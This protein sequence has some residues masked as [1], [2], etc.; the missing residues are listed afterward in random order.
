MSDSTQKKISRIR[1]PRVQIT[2]DVEIGD[3]VEKK[4]L[5]FVVGV[6]ADLSGKRSEER[7]LPK[8]K[9]RKFVSIDRDNFNEVMSGIAPRLSYRVPNSLQNDGS[10]I[11]ANLTFSEMD[12]FSPVQVLKQ[13]SGLKEL[14]E[15]R[16]KLNDLLTKLDGNDELSA[17][18][19]DVIA[20][21][22]KQ[23]ELRKALQAPS[24][25]EP[26]KSE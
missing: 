20:T 13:V 18:L 24:A 25:E 6:M 17:L 7:P 14:Y 3:A 1:P 23:D 15:A 2:Y 16:R 9:E 8:V 21:S 22:E 5:P 19:G 26:A 10:Q 12:D 11:T 4:E